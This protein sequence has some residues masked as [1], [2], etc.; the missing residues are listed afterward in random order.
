MEFVSATSNQADDADEREDDGPDNIWMAASDGDLERVKELLRE[1]VSVN[2][3][4]ENGYTPIHAA[5]SYGHVEL[6]EFLISN[7]ADINL[8]DPD[9]DTPLLVCEEPEIFELLVRAGADPAATNNSGEGILQKAADDE[10]DV[11]LSYLIEQNLVN[12]EEGRKI[13]A[14][15]QEGNMGEEGEYE[16]DDDDDDDEGN[17]GDDTNNGNDDGTRMEG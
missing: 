17:G 7:G 4:D 11:L 6:I 2:A 8:R 10:N 1:G 12:T 16:D 5:V 9:G 15:I 14:T 3:M 13:L